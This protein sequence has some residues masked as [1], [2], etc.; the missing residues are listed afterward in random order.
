M[1]DLLQVD[2]NLVILTMD[3][4]SL[5]YQATLTRVWAPKGQSPVVRLSA[6]R[7]QV[8]FYGALDVR[9]GREIALPALE[10]T[11]QVTADFIRVLLVLF[12]T[13]TI[14]LLLDRAPWHQGA[15]VREVV[16]DND[17]LHTM[18]FPVACPELNPQE[19]IWALA[20]EAISH[21]HCYRDFNQLVADF[22]TFLNENLFESNF[23]DRYG[24]PPNSVILF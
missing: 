23:M 16:A 14:L 1:T 13:H 8:H 2:T 4:M 6:Q 21:N 24:P 20:R 18:F 15:A 7:D 10:Q 19:H 22:E 3:Q 5:H 17:R 11:S 9:G 12:P